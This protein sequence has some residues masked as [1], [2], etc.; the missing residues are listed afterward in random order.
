MWIFNYVEGLYSNPC[1]AALFKSHLYRVYICKINDGNDTRYGM[2]NQ[3]NFAFVVYLPHMENGTVDLD[4]LE[5]KITNS[6]EIQ[7]GFGLVVNENYKFQE[8]LKNV[9]LKV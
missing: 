4:Q 7:S 1:F 6:R 8:K 9:K 2:K 3:E 5:I